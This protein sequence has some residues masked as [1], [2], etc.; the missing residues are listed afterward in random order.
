VAPLSLPP[1]REHLKHG[2]RD[3]RKGRD[4]VVRPDADLAALSA[5]GHVWSNI[6][7]VRASQ[8][9]KTDLYLSAADSCEMSIPRPPESHE[10][11][12]LSAK[13]RSLGR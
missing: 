7:Y 10:L 5:E 6:T 4:A 1:Q 8:T 2:P 12:V 13:P 9:T 3:T 11:V